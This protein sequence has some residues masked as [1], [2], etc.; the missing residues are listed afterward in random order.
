[1]SAYY[2]TTTFPV[3]WQG[4]D[5]LSGLHHYNLYYRLESAGGWNLWLEGVTYTQTT[6]TGTRGYTYHFCSQGVDHLG[7]A[8]ACPPSAA[9][10]PIPSDA[11]AGVTPWSRVNALPAETPGNTIHVTWS[12]APGQQVVYDVQ[13]RD[14]FY[15]LW[16]PW[17]SGVIYTAADFTGQQGHIY[18]FRSRQRAGGIWELY[19]LNYDTYTKLIDLGLG[20]PVP[21]GVPLTIPPDEAPER[22]EEVTRTQPLGTLSGYVAPAGDVDWYRYEL[23][24]TRRLRITL[25]DLPADFDVYVFDGTG[26]FLWASTWGRQLPEEIVVRA[27]AGVYYAQLVGYAGAWSDE[28]P[29]RLAVE[30]VGGGGQGGGAGGGTGAPSSAPVPW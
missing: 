21:P 11:H 27:P 19:P 8:E 14:G 12:G 24:A 6:F 3:S 25:D 28:L 4:A 29:Y 20:G 16:M 26:K 9:G 13:V 23:T 1:M 10:W 7:N 30:V 22:M 18:C 2:T 15:G 5:A 17:K